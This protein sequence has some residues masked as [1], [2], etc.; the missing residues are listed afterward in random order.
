VEDGQ[1]PRRVEASATR[2]VNEDA[3]LGNGCD[4]VRVD[5]V[6]NQAAGCR[7]VDVRGRDALAA[8]RSWASSAF[9][10]SS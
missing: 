1:L 9:S 4:D 7:V 2:L 10:N 5:E 6:V 3:I 8:S